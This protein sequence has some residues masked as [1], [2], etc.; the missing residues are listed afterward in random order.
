MPWQPN[1][2]IFFEGLADHWVSEPFLLLPSVLRPGA[3]LLEYGLSLFPR[4]R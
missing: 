3:D 1:G 2:A 4:S